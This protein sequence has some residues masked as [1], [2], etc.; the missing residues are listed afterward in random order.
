MF[1]A[2][3][4]KVFQFYHNGFKEMTYGKKLWFIILLKL[5]VMFFIFKLFF[6]QNFLNSKFNTDAE[7]GDYVIE[8][9]T[10]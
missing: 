9:L 1:F 6:F 7:K 5:F 2:Q 4:K 10:K 3:I 8:Q